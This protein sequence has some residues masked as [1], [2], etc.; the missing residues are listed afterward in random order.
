MLRLAPLLALLLAAPGRGEETG[1]LLCAFTDGSGTIK[2]L[3]V[4]EG[5]RIVA[6]RD[7]HAYSVDPAL[8]GLGA[9]VVGA[10]VIPFRQGFA[11]ALVARHERTCSYH[12]LV[13]A[14]PDAP[15]RLSPALFTAEGE[16]YRIV[17]LLNPSGD[18]LQIVF[19]RGLLD[20]GPHGGEPEIRVF[21]DNCVSEPS[22]LVTGKSRLAEMRAPG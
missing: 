7:D 20:P 21:A 1:N 19:C 12:Y 22:G 3:A 16:P 9:P 5:V 10:K 2:V 15:A 13:A 4:E 17:E 6:A 18:G 14:R 8:R 11:V